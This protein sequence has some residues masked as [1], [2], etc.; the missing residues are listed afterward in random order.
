MKS[1]CNNI[2]IFTLI[3]V[4][5][6]CET[7]YAVYD[8]SL[9]EAMTPNN[10]KDSNREQRIYHIDSVGIRTYCFENNTVRIIWSPSAYGVGFTIENKTDSSIKVLWDD[11]AFVNEVGTSYHV[12]HLGVTFINKRDPQSPTVIPRKGKLRDLVFPIEYI[13]GDMYGGWDEAPLWPYS[14]GFLEK[15]K[16]QS[17]QFL[18]KSFQVMLPLSNQDVVNEYTFT[19]LINDVSYK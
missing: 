18:G 1:F 15:L 12:I 4:L 11:A 2:A 14:S 9:T 5:S 19:F 16:T 7:Y 17:R 6:G 8:I 10:V 13:Y 3:F